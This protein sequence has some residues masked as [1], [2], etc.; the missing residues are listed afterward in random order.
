MLGPVVVDRPRRAAAGVEVLVLHPGA[1]RR[2]GDGVRDV[3]D[4]LVPRVTP[5]SG[6]A[7]R[8]ADRLLDLAADV[9]R[10]APP[11]HRDPRRSTLQ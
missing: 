9:R 6:I 3:T 5:A 10:L 8:I 7:G 2:G 4:R 11:D 1:G